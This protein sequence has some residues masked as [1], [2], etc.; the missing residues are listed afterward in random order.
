MPNIL[1]DRIIAYFQ[2]ILSADTKD[3]Y[4]YEVLGRY[5]D[6]D[7]K[8]KSLRPFFSNPDI[9]HEEALK[10]DRIVRTYALQKY[11]EEKRGE[12]LFIN[13]RLAWLVSYAEKPEEMITLQLAEKFGITPEK[14]VIEIT[15]EE[16]NA[17]EE[18]IRSIIHYK[19]IGCRIA[20]D[21]YGKRASNI[22]R[23]A[24]IQPDIIKINMDYIHKSEE[25]S[26]YQEYLRYIAAFAETVG[27][28]VLYEGVETQRQLDMCISSKGRY[29]QGFLI[30]LPQPSMRDSLIQRSVFSA[31][32][33]DAYNALQKRVIS[34]ESLRN[35]LDVQVERF[36]LENPF[37]SEKTNS[38]VYL[39][40]LFR[41]LPGLKRIYLCGRQGVQLS[42]NIERQ[43]EDIVCRNY[44]NKNW[45]WRGY[46]HETITAF[47]MGRKS[48]LSNLYRD[49]TTKEQMFT[50]CYAIKDNLLLFVDITGISAIK[51][52]DTAASGD[53]KTP[54]VTRTRKG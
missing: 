41:E 34:A 6:D 48:C 21:D 31:S 40:K 15:E 46:F 14:L 35:S 33:E 32:I 2:P 27:I 45:A 43:S 28:E 17:N 24:K 49:F 38:D 39:M 26:Y 50:Y 5:I 8:V 47:A 1:S 23:L 3:V 25:S 54:P 11:A 13:I 44:R 37:D 10:M 12:Y 18:Y 53:I 29:Y 36:L 51:T 16:F 22:D 30:G 9:S 20:L 42:D 4:G 52:A 19:K 7:G